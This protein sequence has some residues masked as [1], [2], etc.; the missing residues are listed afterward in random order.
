MRVRFAPSPTG[1]LHIGN[2][3]TAVANF[4]FARREGAEYI[5]R[6]EDTD[7]ERSTKESELSIMDDL[8]WLGITWDEG[9]DTGGNFGPYRQSERYDI[10]REYTEKLLASG[11]AYHCYCSKEE[12]DSAREAA[13]KAGGSFIYPGT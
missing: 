5:L 2:A 12:I 6:I 7:S 9:P 4:A 8:R 11:H 1:F 13:E 10:Y 3:R